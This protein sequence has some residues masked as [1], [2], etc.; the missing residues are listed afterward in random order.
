MTEK[1]SLCASYESQLAK[2]RDDHKQ[3][4]RRLREQATSGVADL[5]RS[6][7]ALKRMQEDCECR[8]ARLQ[9]EMYRFRREKEQEIS[10]L[11]QQIEKEKLLRETDMLEKDR[12]CRFLEH[13]KNAV[14]RELLKAQT[15]RSQMERQHHTEVQNLAQQQEKLVTVSS[16][17]ISDWD[18]RSSAVETSFNHLRSLLHNQ[19]YLNFRARIREI[20]LERKDYTAELEAVEERKQRDTQF[21]RD[22]LHQLRQNQ[23]GSMASIRRFEEDVMKHFAHSNKG[24]QSN[25]NHNAAATASPL[26]SSLST[27]AEPPGQHP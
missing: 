8:V 15:E 25:G 12:Q 9:E 26:S 20:A 4:T 6:G 7:E 1:E 5:Q 17:L 11:N 19:D 16:R 27:G 23:E 2:V 3:E 13:E 18:N 14:Q 24:Q 21:L 22:I 10:R